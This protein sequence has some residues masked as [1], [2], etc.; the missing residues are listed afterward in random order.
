MFVGTLVDLK[1][2][3]FEVF[4]NYQM[5]RPKVFNTFNYMFISNYIANLN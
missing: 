4:L 5:S 1:S 3:I 2:F